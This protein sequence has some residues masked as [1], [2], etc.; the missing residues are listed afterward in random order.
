M[1]PSTRRRRLTVALALA[2]VFAIAL[3][4]APAALASAGGGSNSFGGGGGGG[5]GG[6]SGG[7]GKGFAL[8]LIFRAILDVVLLT[9][10]LV[11]VLVIALIVLAIAYFFYG[12]RLR[13]W[14]ANRPRQG[15]A[16]RRQVS[17]RRRKVELAAAEAAEDDP[18]FAPDVVRSEAARLFTQVQSAWDGGN[19]VRL[20][21]LVAPALLEEWERRLD[22]FARRGWRNRVKPLGDPKVEYV[23]LRRHGGSEEDRVV[24]RI[25]AKLE[26]Y[27][28][29]RYGHHIKRS[30][31]L[32]ETTRVREF[33]TLGRRA[34]H[35]ILVSIEQGAEGEHALADTVA[36]TPW[37]DEQALQDQA[38]VEG[39]VADAVPEGT[40]VAEVADLGYQGDARAAALDLSLADGRFAPDVLEVAA[41][42][43]VAAWA[44]AVDGDD[45][46]LLAL[47]RTDA[48]YAL[49]H[50]EGGSTRLVVRGPQVRQIRILALDAGATP[51]TMTIEV[52][53]TGRRYLEDRDTT[54]VVSGSQTKNVKFTEHWTLAL[55]GPDEQP[56][57]I[58]QVGAPPAVTA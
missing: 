15:R 44:D 28:E 16:A 8:Y 24:V 23:G 30:G 26:D 52:A 36:P 29:D 48:A 10:G 53:L 18:A 54:A 21:A 43:A 31:R 5:L 11:R 47:A 4:V 40:S 20:R 3:I 1:S 34:G 42:Q 45:R 27:V 51:P 6:H 32:T 2:L 35:W 25:E 12:R 39:A 19:R 41:R 56:W 58:A 9:H 49:L 37:S 13:A 14:W 57:Q 38:L 17:Q 22:D 55:E 50:P 46:A 7:S 33:W